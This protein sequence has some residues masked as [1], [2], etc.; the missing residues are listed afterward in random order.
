MRYLISAVLMCIAMILGGCGDDS[1]QILPTAPAVSEDFIASAPF[2]DTGKQIKVRVF[3]LETGLP[4]WVH[5]DFR[6]D[7]H[8]IDGLIAESQEFFAREMDRHGYGRK[9]FDVIRNGVGDVH[10]TTINLDASDI[11]WLQT[12]EPP[13]RDIIRHFGLENSFSDNTF[14]GNNLI[15]IFFIDMN[16]TMRG[17]QVGGYAGYY[18]GCIISGSSWNWATVAHELGHAFGLSHNFR[19]GSYIMS[20]G[21]NPSKVGRKELSAG[22]AGVLNRH[23]AFNSGL[24]LD[25]YQRH[26]VWL[27]PCH[28]WQFG[29]ESLFHMYNNME[30]RESDSTVFEFRIAY[31]EIFHDLYLMYDYAYLNEMSEVNGFEESPL[32]AESVDI[33]FSGDEAIYRIVFNE[34]LMPT[35]DKV[36]MHMLGPNLAPQ[37]IGNPHVFFT[38][39]EHEGPWSHADHLETGV[40]CRLP[41]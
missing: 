9:T 20:Y 38:F 19:D 7:V 11:S 18:K 12:E 32:F 4:L 27:T 14:L 34:E 17:S 41:H 23:P 13:I 5:P 25:T 1:Q 37:Q 29:F 28:T 16:V 39:P 6:P 33:S 15:D 26:L 10:I 30:L 8:R 24:F 31:Y 22:A 40:P 36:H 35:T 3:Y 21:V 2:R